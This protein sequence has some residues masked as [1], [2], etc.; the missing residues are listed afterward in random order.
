MK[1]TTKQNGAIL[2]I[3]LIIVLVIMSISAIALEMSLLEFKNTTRLNTTTVD[4]YNAENCLHETAQKIYSA[5]EPL[6]HSINCKGKSCVNDYTLLYFK[7]LPISWWETHG[8]FCAKNIWRYTELLAEKTSDDYT[9]Y[10]ITVYYYPYGLLQMTIGK[11]FIMQQP[12][13]QSWQS[14]SLN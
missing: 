1:Y 3:M 4:F 9:F 14:T 12:V 11:S 7:Q 2:I 5:T 8:N 6:A 10:R 13:I